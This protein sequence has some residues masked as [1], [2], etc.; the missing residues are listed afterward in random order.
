[1]VLAVE[2]N[3]VVGYALVCI[4]DDPRWHGRR[5]RALRKGLLAVGGSAAL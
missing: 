1:L 2:G 3:E 5:R 4:E